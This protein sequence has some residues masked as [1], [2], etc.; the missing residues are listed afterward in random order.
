MAVSISGMFGAS[1]TYFADSPV[2]IDISGLEW[3][4]SSPFNIVRVQVIYNGGVIGDF[5]ADT[6]GQPSISFDISSA[7][8]AI[9]CGYEYGDE[10]AKAG[11]AAAAST[12]GS[13][14]SGSR[15]YRSYSLIVFTEYI[16]SVDGEL[17]ITSSGT[18]SG[19]RCMIGWLTERERSGIGDKANADASHW[20]HTNNR[21][22]DASTKPK[23]VP[24]RV[25][26]NSI[27][28]WVDV[29][30]SGTQSV[31]YAAASTPAADSTSAH[32]PRVL[33]DD[34][35]YTDFLFVNRRGAVETCS[36]QTLEALSVGVEK[37]QYAR[38]GRPA[39]KPSRSLASV[40][41]DGPRKS[42]AMSSGHQTREWADWWAQE[43]L[44]SGRHWMLYEGAFVPVI[45]E[46]AKKDSGIYD[47]VKQQMPSVDFTVTLAL[48]G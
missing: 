43:F 15:G 47:R 24:E 33:R 42:F 29:S 14:T 37:E 4:V 32:A 45:V 34:I 7:L 39:F 23:A 28:S 12:G 38:V 30:N 35:P 25:G 46:P 11:E 10:V 40:R 17:T 16:N 48:E 31:F 3:P 20:E 26:S 27:T 22:G 5:H 44:A 21:N 6:G 13:H 8:R 1:K 41:K 19:G 9:W 18:I 36:A 2:V